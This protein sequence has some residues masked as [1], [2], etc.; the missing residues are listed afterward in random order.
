M[1]KAGTRTENAS[2]RRLL[3]SGARR[4]TITITYRRRTI[5][6]RRRT[7]TTTARRR[8]ITYRRRTITTTNTAAAKEESVTVNAMIARGTDNSEACLTSFVHDVS[9]FPLMQYTMAEE[10]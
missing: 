6:Y 10:I 3:G 2:G 4:R 9:E 7:I 5:T 8:T 1:D